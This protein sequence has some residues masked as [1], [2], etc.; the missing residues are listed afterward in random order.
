MTFRAKVFIGG[1]IL[2]GLL[3]LSVF[4]FIPKKKSTEV[5]EAPLI[6]VHE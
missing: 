1:S 2:V 3:I 6:Q 4:L 5:I